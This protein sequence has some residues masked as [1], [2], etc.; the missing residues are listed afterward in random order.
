MP[1]ALHGLIKTSRWFKK[2]LLGKSQ[3]HVAATLKAQ[4]HRIQAS[5]ASCRIAQKTDAVS[6]TVQMPVEAIALAGFRAFGGGL[7]KLGHSVWTMNA[8][9]DD[10]QLERSPDAEEPVDVAQFPKRKASATYARGDILSVCGLPAEVLYMAG[11]RRIALRFLGSGI[12]DVQS[13]L[14]VE[15]PANDPFAAMAEAIK[16]RCA[17]GGWSSPEFARELSSLFNCYGI[18]NDLNTP[19]LDLAASVVQALGQVAHTARRAHRRYAAN[20]WVSWNGLEMRDYS[21]T[22]IGEVKLQDAGWSWELA[23]LGQTVAT[24]GPYATEADAKNACDQK[25]SSYNKENDVVSKTAVQPPIIDDEFYLGKRVLWT[26]ESGLPWEGHVT[27]A[28]WTMDNTPQLSVRYNTP[29]RGQQFRTVLPIEENWD[30]D[31]ENQA[32]VKAASRRT[33]SVL[34]IRDASRPILKSALSVDEPEFLVGYP[35]LNTALGGKAREGEVVSVIPGHIR[36][37]DYKLEVKYYDGN[38]G[39][40]DPESW[41]IDGGYL[42][43]ARQKT[44]QYLYAVSA[45]VRGAPVEFHVEHGEPLS[46]DAPVFL[47]TALDEYENSHGVVSGSFDDA[48]LEEI[49]SSLQVKEE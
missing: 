14:A 25:A 39:T 17:V 45:T 33:A 1:N 15:S 43:C 16:A 18:D 20:N 6:N 3:A 44:A 13:V 11:P 24:G 10:V 36:H 49:V 5:L 30:F 7:F 29:D 48:E 42:V 28:T 32:L 35:V 31:I 47:E 8:Q 23:Q 21:A 26:P 4:G 34:S 46:L 41:K 27:E 12:V 22:L 2:Q 40:I 9:G 19:D 37:D 38:Y